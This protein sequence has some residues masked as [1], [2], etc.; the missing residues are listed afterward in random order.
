MAIG[1]AAKNSRD[2]TLVRLFCEADLVKLPAPTERVIEPELLGP[3]LSLRKTANSQAPFG[4]QHRITQSTRHMCAPW[5]FSFVPVL[6]VKRR[7]QW[8]CGNSE[9]TAV[10]Q[11]IVVW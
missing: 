7:K 4:V 8:R 2:R 6:S 11:G 9:A 5:P 1:G 3:F 10:H